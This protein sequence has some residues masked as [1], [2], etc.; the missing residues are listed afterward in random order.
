MW[1]PRLRC[2][3]EHRMQIKQPS[4]A[5]AHLGAMLYDG[6]LPW[7][8]PFAPQSQQT[9]LHSFFRSASSVLLWEAFITLIFQWKSVSNT[10]IR[11]VLIPYH[12]VIQE[13]WK[14]R[15]R[16]IFLFFW[17]TRWKLWQKHSGILDSMLKWS[18]LSSSPIRLHVC[19]FL[20]ISLPERVESAIKEA[21]VESGCDRV[22]GNLMSLLLRYPDS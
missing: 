12:Q 1:T 22:I 11:F 21:G 2:T 4:V 16:A 17:S 13:L 7:F 15:N 6:S 18:L 20:S 8:L 19:F 3:P 5:E 14:C 9:L 10:N